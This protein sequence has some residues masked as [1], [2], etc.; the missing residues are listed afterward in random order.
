MCTGEDHA[1]PWKNL[2]GI[3]YSK[4]F[5]TGMD[6]FWV[7]DFVHLDL[8][9]YLGYGQCK[10]SKKKEK[11]TK[12]A[13]STW[14]PQYWSALEFGGTPASGPRRFHPHMVDVWCM[15]W[16]KKKK[17]KKMVDDIITWRNDLRLP[18]K[19]LCRWPLLPDLM[20]GA[21]VSVIL[22]SLMHAQC[23]LEVAKISLQSRGDTCTCKWVIFSKY[24][25]FNGV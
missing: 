17:E 13:L 7:P 25:Q 24:N 14:D 16:E 8:A 23:I 5:K 21:C 19:Q 12:P 15:W 22:S 6:F 9:S 10:K 4:I 3:R 20:R 1:P 2:E 18:K 11:M